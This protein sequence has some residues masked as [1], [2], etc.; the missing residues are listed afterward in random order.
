MPVTLTLLGGTRPENIQSIVEIIKRVP[1]YRLNLGSD[2]SGIAPIIRRVLDGL[3]TEA[4][5]SS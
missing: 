4:G 5:A 2:R 1:V 3:E